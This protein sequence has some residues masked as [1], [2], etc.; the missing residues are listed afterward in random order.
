MKNILFTSLVLIFV[1]QA[2]CTKKFC[3]SGLYQVTLE[4]FEP[5]ELDT[6]IMR[7]YHKNS[8]FTSLI[9]SSIVSTSQRDSITWIL[10]PNSLLDIHR[11]YQFQFSGLS[12]VYTLTDFQ[13]GKK[14][15]NCCFPFR[16]KNDYYDAL[17]AYSI[18]G[19]RKSKGEL[20]ISK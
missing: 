17:E 4:G 2:C 7:S 1:L 10:Y 16:P 12:Q 9:D 18:N 6:I 8:N 13:V 19:I 3:E 11:D 15:C 20:Y 14:G 5:S